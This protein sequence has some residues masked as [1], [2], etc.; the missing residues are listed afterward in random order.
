MSGL[1]P[2]RRP[3]LYKTLCDIIGLVWLATTSVDVARP[4][5][6]RRG[7]CVIEDSTSVFHPYDDQ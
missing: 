3:D 1:N 6:G 2:E 4:T 5:T 7:S